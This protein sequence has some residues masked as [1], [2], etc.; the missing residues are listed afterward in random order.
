MES[1]V[2]QSPVVYRLS[3][4]VIKK[5][6]EILWAAVAILVIGAGI[7]FVISQKSKKQEVANNALSK[8]IVQSA[9][10]GQ[11][12]SLEGLL[13]VASDHPGTDAAGRA[14]LL[15][16]TRQYA[17]GKFPEAKQYYEKFLHEYGNS[18]FAGE[19]WYGIAAC[20]ESEGK[21]A[22]A[23]AAYKNITEHRPNDSTI[24]QVKLALGRLYESSGKPEAAVAMFKEVARRDYGSVGSEAFMHLQELITKHPN[25]AM[26][27]PTPTAPTTPSA[28]MAPSTS[29]NSPLLNLKVR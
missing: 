27:T 28:P 29:T 6:K 9:M 25:L 14:M 18:L 2:T 12:A 8:V 15:A 10:T 13:K 11:A 21:T 3:A 17:D 24:P 19:A 16:G 4:W 22:E 5:Q 26:A 20:L 1:D 7:G 23:T